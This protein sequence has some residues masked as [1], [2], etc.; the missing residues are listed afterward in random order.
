[1]TREWL[2]RPEGGSIFWIEIPTQDA[3]QTAKQKEN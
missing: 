1:V 3:L 2:D